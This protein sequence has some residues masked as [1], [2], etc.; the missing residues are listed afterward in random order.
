M[1]TNRILKFL[2]KY[3]LIYLRLKHLN[4]MQMLTTF[5]HRPNHQCHQYSTKVKTSMEENSLT[6]ILSEKCD[7]KIKNNK[8]KINFKSIFYSLFK[9]PAIKRKVLSIMRTG[10]IAKGSYFTTTKC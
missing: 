3:P 6:K 8:N 10:S 9:R 7:M 2:I 1:I 5:S 4:E